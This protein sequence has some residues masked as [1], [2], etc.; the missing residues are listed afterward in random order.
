M[1]KLHAIAQLQAISCIDFSLQNLVA[2][3]KSSWTLKWLVLLYNKH[4]SISS[5]I[6]I[7][8]KGENE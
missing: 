3:A 7:D 8:L 2:E 1:Y 5:I 4:V 6:R